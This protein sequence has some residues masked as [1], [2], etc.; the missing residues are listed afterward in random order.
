[1]NRAILRVNA[2]IR[3]YYFFVRKWEKP[4]TDLFFSVGEVAVTDLAAAIDDG[5]HAAAQSLGDGIC[6]FWLYVNFFFLLFLEA[7]AEAEAATVVVD[8]RGI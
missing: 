4:L 2:L 6:A 3:Y 8:P 5:I 7:T 1:M